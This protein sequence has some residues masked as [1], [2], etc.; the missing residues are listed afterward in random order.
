MFIESIQN[1]CRIFFDEWYTERRI[2]TD[3]TFQNDIGSTQSV[4]SPK[5]LICAHQ[6]AGRSNPPNKRTNI[7]VFDNLNVRKHFIEIDGVRYPRDGALTNYILNDYSDQFK[8]VE[9]IMKNML[10]KNY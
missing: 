8:D 7:S 1:N 10:V 6:T 2:A 9:L 3:Q 5:Y 4:K